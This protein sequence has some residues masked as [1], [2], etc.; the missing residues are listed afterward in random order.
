MYFP[1]APTSELRHPSQLYEAFFEGILLFVLLWTLRKKLP[2]P[3]SLSGIYLFGYGFVRFF[4]EFFRE[5]DIQL[6]FVFLNFSMGQL[7]CC[8]MM[9][10][11]LA[12]LFKV[13]ISSGISLFVNRRY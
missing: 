2:L 5:P 7:L 6:G 1:S 10:A 12:L 11:G 3:G 4:I 9:I 13:I 8:V